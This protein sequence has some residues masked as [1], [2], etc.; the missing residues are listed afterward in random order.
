MLVVVACRTYVAAAVSK[1][2]LDALQFVIKVPIAVVVVAVPTR[3][4][5]GRYIQVAFENEQPVSELPTA[6]EPRTVAL[7]PAPTSIVVFR[8]ATTEI[9][10]CEAGGVEVPFTTVVPPANRN[11][12]SAIV[13]LTA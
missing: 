9:R 6:T 7:C 10:N 3:Q 2:V 4:D 12:E 11:D 8:T 5:A 1:V 13:L